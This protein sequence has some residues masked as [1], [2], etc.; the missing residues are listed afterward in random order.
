MRA[1]FGDAPVPYHE[2]AV[3]AAYRREPVSDDEAR[4]V[5]EYV[6]DRVLYELLGFGVDGACR[7]VEHEQ[8]RV[9]EHHA[10]KREKLFLFC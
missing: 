4:T 9:L 6:R 1:G 5:G 8:A 2:D 10:R 3:G 7:L